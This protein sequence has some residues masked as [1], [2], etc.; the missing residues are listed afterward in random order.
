MAKIVIS[1]RRADTEAVT[2]RIRDRLVGHYGS[3]SVF[4]D[5]DS[6]PFGI[7]FRDYIKEALD[8]TDILLAIMGKQWLGG[9]S[10]QSRIMEETDPV[11]IEVE[12]ALAR[13]IAVIPVLID[14]ATMPQ[15]ADL[16]DSLKNLAYRNAA[17]VDSGRDFHLHMD[18]I[19]RSMDKLLGKVEAARP[20]ETH[21][22][23]ADA[24]AAAPTHLASAPPPPSPAAAPQITAM[25]PPPPPPKRGWVKWVA[26][27]VGV[28]F[29]LLGVLAM[30]GML[31]PPQPKPGEPPRVA[32]APTA[33]TPAPSP[34]AQSPPTPAPSP[35]PVTPAPA[36]SIVLPTPAADTPPPKCGTGANLAFQDTFATPAAGWDDTSA[37]RF[38]A[39]NQMVF[40][41][42][43][44]G[45]LT[46]L[47]RPI[48]F[49]NGTVC[50]TIKAPMQANK[51]DG[52]ASGGLVFWATDY[53]NYY[54]A[55]IYLDG[56]YQV[57]RRLSNEWIPVVRRTKSEHIRSGLG[58]TNALQV[59]LKENNG[60]FYVNGQ[61][62]TEFRGQPPEHGGAFGLHG[63]SEA[64]RGGEWRFLDVA[65]VDDAAPP[66]KKPSAK[67]AR[68][69]SQP[70]VCK[71]SSDA[72][73]ADD[74]KKVDAGWGEMTQTA[75][76]DNGL[77]VLKPQPNRTR[78]VLYLSLRYANATLCGNVKWPTN[79]LEK[80][81][82]ASGGVAFWATNY[83]NFYEA[84]IYRD[85]SYDVYRLLDDQWY[86][87][88]K[89]TK[90]S[91]VKTGL[92]AVNQ[93]KVAMVNNKATLFIN[94][95]KIIEFF[96]Q[97]PVRGGAVGLFAQSDKERQNDWRF[98]DI[99][100]VD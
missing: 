23:P 66:A 19:I 74:F 92:D 71:T 76:Y 64:D 3:E 42:K 34:P 35:A 49:K 52:V 51:L 47:Y 5:I 40:N 13:G 9:S 95:V 62:L 37:S 21:A 77:L 44:P 24:G 20:A 78:T 12:T 90:S 59:S 58:A 72:A 30:I 94:D 32:Q 81:E 31:L 27:A 16:P 85:G 6:I 11:R 69:A 63:E 88:V 36:P 29:V 45:L 38:F 22:A 84:S 99:V 86:A 41:F 7:D 87:I 28:P 91:A 48:Q 43:D 57:Y 25:P 10:G 79:A 65:V 83:K 80:D 97:Q 75:Y 39:D 53:S 82:I 67:A 54:L 96:G 56:T 15:P 93:L 17:Y 2:G 73:F 14:E 8:E 61:K 70:M 89:R 100:V 26:I 55:Q 4:M 1:Y 68:A 46:W 18:R 98:Q 60:T 50:G 33:P